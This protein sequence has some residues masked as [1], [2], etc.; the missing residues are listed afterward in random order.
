[1]RRLQLD[2]I[3]TLKNCHRL[4]NVNL[5]YAIAAMLRTRTRVAFG[6]DGS[7]ACE[8]VRAVAHA[9]GATA[10]APCVRL[11]VPCRRCAHGAEARSDLAYR[12]AHTH[13]RGTCSGRAARTSFFLL[14]GLFDAPTIRR[15]TLVGNPVTRVSGYRVFVVA[16]LP[17]L[18][19][20]DGTY[21]Y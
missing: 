17:K 9:T 14:I 15:L 19:E 8:R 16:N 20:L 11:K 21:A 12:C 2:E 7:R 6:A 1:M 13:A 18:R 5:E 4:R 10:F 3:G